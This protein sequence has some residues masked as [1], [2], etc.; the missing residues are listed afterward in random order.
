[1]KHTNLPR[2]IF[3]NVIDEIP[4]DVSL[5]KYGKNPGKWQ[6][7]VMLYTNPENIKMNGPQASKSIGYTAGQIL[8]GG[9]KTPLAGIFTKALITGQP[10][11]WTFH[12][13]NQNIKEGDRHQYF[14]PLS[15]NYIAAFNIDIDAEVKAKKEKAE[16]MKSLEELNQQLVE[17]ELQMIQLKSEIVE[18]ET[19]VTK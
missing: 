15:N 14:V 19:R 16:K 8:I 9:E 13:G 1:M 10:Q 2:F 5:W 4:C 7:C 17:R 3:K 18:L 12:F 6:D 11:E